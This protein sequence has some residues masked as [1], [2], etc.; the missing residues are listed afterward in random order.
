MIE[1]FSLFSGVEIR[2]HSQW[3]LGD[4]FPNFETKSQSSIESQGYSRKKDL[5][6]EDAGDIFF[7]GWLVL[8]VF[9][10]YGSLVSDQI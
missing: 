4:F 3:N 7:Y 10:L 6:G 1:F 9:K 2:S 8:K 5:G